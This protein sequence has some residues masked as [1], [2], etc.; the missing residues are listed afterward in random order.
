[1]KSPPRV[2]RSWCTSVVPLLFGFKEQHGDSLWLATKFWVV[3]LARGMLNA[4]QNPKQHVLT[5][6]FDHRE[7]TSVERHDYGIPHLAL[8]G[9]MQ[10]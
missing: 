6:C 5:V 7:P 8:R 2:M 10:V 1:M 3:Y 4:L 9:W